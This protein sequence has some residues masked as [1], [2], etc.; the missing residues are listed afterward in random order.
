MDK[1][2]NSKST[3]ESADTL[4]LYLKQTYIHPLYINCDCEDEEAEEAE[5]YLN[6]LFTRA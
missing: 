3:H 2:Y 1:Y 5:F 6:A 4:D